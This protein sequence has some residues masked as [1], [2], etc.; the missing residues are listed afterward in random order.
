MKQI[1]NIKTILPVVLLLVMLSVTGCSEDFLDRTPQDNYTE[2]NYWAS[3]EALRLAVDPLYNRAWF[4]FHERSMFG[5]GSMRG[6]DAFNNYF[7]AE[8]V[9]FQTTSLTTEV[10]KAWSSL[11]AVIAMSN[12]VIDGV[13]HKCI[14]SDDLTQAMKDRTLGEAYLWR[15]TAYFFGVRIWGPMILSEDNAELVRNPIRPLN[16]EEDIFKFIVRDLR[17]ACKL[18][19]ETRDATG[20]ATVWAAKAQLAKVL[21]AQSGWDKDKRNDDMLAECI[22]LCEDVIENSGAT[23]IN[24]EDLFKYQNNVNDESLLAFRWRVAPT[25][26]WG[27]Q[28]TL[29]SDLSWSDVTDVTSWNNNMCA[30]IDM[31]E[32]YNLDPLTHDAIRRK[33]TFF[34]PGEHYDYI[35]AAKGGYTYPIGKNVVGDN[36][37]WMQVKKGVVGSKADND[38]NLD[39]MNSPLHT[40]IIR[41]ADVLLTHAEACLGNQAELT[42]GRGLESFNRVR[43]RAGV[44]RKDKITFQDIMNERRIEFCMEYQTWFELMT[45]YRWKPEFMMNYFNNV[46]KRGYNITDGN[47]RLNADGSISW[48]MYGNWS[49]A[50]NESVPVWDTL[51]DFNSSSY[52]PTV[53]TPANVF[54]PYPE[55]DLLANPLLSKPPVPYVF[56]EDE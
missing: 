19:P 38:G 52:I 22:K 35:W 30:T 13:L 45:W 4:G 32:L 8:F 53:V 28:N 14:D 43:D 41:F 3:D 31:I 23:L 18:L 40:H 26:I 17:R 29:V 37:G 15:A 48:S 39:M 9:R 6:N 49:D 7:T 36:V 46:Q 42:G 51:E 16:P 55:A 50:L 20:R 54:I 56:S 5:L 1:I 44:S 10:A 34:I 2:D 27:T 12:A 11:Y 33:A 25:A 47:I 21:L 24:Y